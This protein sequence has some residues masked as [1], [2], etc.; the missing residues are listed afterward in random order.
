MWQIDNRTPFASGQAWVR[1]LD[2]AETWIVVVKA[3]FDVHPDGTTAISRDQPEVTRSPVYSGAPGQS[4]IVLDN[5]FILTKP[6]TDIVVN[7]TAYAPRGSA[8][9]V[10]VALRIGSLHKRL[11]VFGD[12]TW[13]RLGGLEAPAPFATMPLVYERAFGGVDAG[14]PRPERDWYWPNPVGTGFVASR[15]RL[16]GVRAPNIE[17]PDRL[18]TAWDDRPEPA[19]FGIV[20]SHWESRARLA[21]TYDEVWSTTR[22][23]LLPRDFDDRYFQTVPPDQ[24]SSQPLSGGEAVVLDNLTPG[25]R[26][27]FRLPT[28]ELALSTR[29][30]DASRRD[31]G[32]PRLHTVIL[33]PDQMRVSLVWHSAMECHSKVYELDHTRVTMSDLTTSP[34]EREEEVE[35][36]LDLL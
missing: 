29:F 19:G 2:G 18:I 20:G 12:R 9:S 27:A 5:D 36:L 14:S 34:D 3:T 15:S 35:S 13:H 7:G 30:M 32:P 10:D 4:S 1:D 25:G 21:G 24:Q 11:R 23:P 22:Q 26:L 16:A 8:T 6:T 33:E 17:Y 31:P 28:V